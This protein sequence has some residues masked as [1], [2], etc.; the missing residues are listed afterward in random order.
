[1]EKAREEQTESR[2]NGT[3]PSNCLFLFPPWGPDSP[4]CGAHWMRWFYD[5]RKRLKIGEV[6]DKRAEPGDHNHSNSGRNMTVESTKVTW[7]NEIIL[8]IKCMRGLLFFPD[9]RQM[10]V[11]LINKNN[12][13]K[14][15]E[16]AE[17]KN[18][19]PHDQKRLTDCVC[20]V[21]CV[22]HKQKRN[23]LMFSAGTLTIAGSIK[24]SART[25]AP[26]SSVSSSIVAAWLC[27]VEFMSFQD[28]RA[29]GL[30]RLSTV[31]TIACIHRD[32][33]NVSS[34]FGPVV[35]SA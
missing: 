4:S 30:R 1:M 15:G 19:S 2:E 10:F 7:M 6:W 3:M 33:W 35:T 22:T 34:L 24:F 32:K 31:S 9:V 16:K 18:S 28:F 25:N 29:S 20:R 5:A 12:F 21:S 13:C 11:F 17:N 27:S 23:L 26:S 8:L 14:K